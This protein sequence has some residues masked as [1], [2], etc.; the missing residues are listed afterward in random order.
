MKATVFFGVHRFVHR[1][2]HRRTMT[3]LKRPHAP[4]VKQGHAIPVPQDVTQIGLEAGHGA[5]LPAD[6]SN[7][8]LL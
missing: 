5:Q 7:P 3:I 8:T 6:E 4:E 1:V 2:G